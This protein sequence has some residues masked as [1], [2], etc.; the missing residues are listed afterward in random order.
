MKKQAVLD[1]E[2]TKFKADF[3][4]FKAGDTIAV[5]CKIEEGGKERIQIFKG[6]CISRHGEGMG[7]SFTVRKLTQSHG[8]ERTFPVE[9]PNI[10]K[11]VVERAGKVKRSKL[12][13]LRDRVGK[14]TRIA[15]KVTQKREGEEEKK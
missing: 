14:A 13:Y 11:V 15:Q 2:K 12:F 4:E 1:Y 9:S 8:I 5:H 10:A 7:R 6:T 3:P